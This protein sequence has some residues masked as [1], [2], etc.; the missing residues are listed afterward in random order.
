MY[1]KNRSRKRLATSSLNDKNRPDTRTLL[2]TPRSTRFKSIFPDS[3]PNP[4]LLEVTRKLYQIIE[5]SILLPKK[6]GEKISSL[7]SESAADIKTLAATVLDIVEQSSN[8]PLLN[9][10]LLAADEEDHQIERE[11]AGNNAFGCKVPDVVEARLDNIDKTL[12]DL[13]KALLLPSGAFSFNLPAQKKATVPSYALAASKHAP[14]SL[15]PR[16]TTAFHP[17]ASKKQPPPPPL[18]SPLAELGQAGSD[19]RRGLCASLNDIPH[20]DH[21]DQHHP[22]HPQRS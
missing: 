11:L 13:K 14:N 5:S 2:G 15:N 4:T 12:S 1:E 21:N 9:R 10:R 18:P 16:P 7:G 22:N 6:G 20:G 8:I 17:V 19:G 3:T